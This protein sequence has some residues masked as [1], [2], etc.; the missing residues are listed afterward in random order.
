EADDLVPPPVPV[1]PGSVVDSET[2]E[3]YDIPPNHEI[4]DVPPSA[5]HSDNAIRDEDTYDIPP[6]HRAD[7]SQSGI[8]D[9]NVYDVPPSSIRN[10]SSYDI[11]L[12][13][14]RN[15]NAIDVPQSSI[16]NESSYDI[17]PSNQFANNFR[18][19]SSSTDELAHKFTEISMKNQSAS[20][21][22]GSNVLNDFDQHVPPRPPQ[23]VDKVDD[24]Y[25]YLAEETYIKTSSMGA[26]DFVPAPRPAQ[27]DITNVPIIPPPRPPKPSQ[28]DNGHSPK[29]PSTP[30]PSFDDRVFLNDSTVNHTL[31]D[32]ELANKLDILKKHDGAS[33]DS[34]N[35]EDDYDV[36]PSNK[37]ANYLDTLIPLQHPG[38]DY[39]N[40]SHERPGYVDM[41]GGCNP[42]ITDTYV[43]AGN[44]EVLPMDTTCTYTPMAGIRHPTPPPAAQLPMD[45]RPQTM[46][47]PPPINRDNKPGRKSMG[48]V[49]TKSIPPPLTLIGTGSYYA[50]KDGMFI[51]SPRTRSFRKAELLPLPDNAK[52]GDE[53]CD[54]LES[55]SSSSDGDG[56]LKD[57][58]YIQLPMPADHQSLELYVTHDPSRTQIYENSRELQRQAPPPPPGAPSRKSKKEPPKKTSEVQYIDLALDEPSD[59][60]PPPRPRVPA[61]PETEYTVLDLEK[62]QGL[63]A[64]LAQRTEE[65]NKS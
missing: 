65:L 44:A 9:D 46:I 4:Y 7:I 56:A 53:R 18:E 57:G 8:L 2:N 48:D 33:T 52:D 47:V 10:E 28:T 21:S 11:P 30:P 36:P 20:R 43:P 59:P 63:Q 23:R 14:I 34:S 5:I 38:N 50:S 39:S 24:E 26:Y 22:D 41:T 17:P 60:Q 13:S 49:M 45:R 35:E 12:S 29:I 19:R 61:S 31:H 64:A 3:I 25:V 16:R 15:E 37:P 62:T 1:R 51:Q 54:T 6:S 40:I 27:M 58:N 55:S 32:R 42:H